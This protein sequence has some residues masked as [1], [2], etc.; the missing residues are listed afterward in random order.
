MTEVMWFLAIATG[1]AVTVSPDLATRL[2]V[3]MLGAFFAGVCGFFW[4]V[5]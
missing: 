2:M 1:L 5:T 3:R 4:W